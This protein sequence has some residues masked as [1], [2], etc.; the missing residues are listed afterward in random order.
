ML[1][2]QDE[3][4]LAEKVHKYFCLYDKGRASALV[5]TNE[6]HHAALFW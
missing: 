6:I 2:L 1:S 3:E 4:I 5:L